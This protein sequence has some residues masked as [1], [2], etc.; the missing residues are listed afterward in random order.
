MALKHKKKEIQ[1][2]IKLFEKEADQ[3]HDI[4]FK[5]FM[6]TKDGVEQNRVFAPQNHAIVLQQYFGRITNTE[7]LINNW[8]SSDLQWGLRGAYSTLC[9]VIEGEQC[10]HFV[11]MAKRTGNIFN[12]HDTEIF[13]S[14]YRLKPHP[15]Y[16][17]VNGPEVRSTNS[18]KLALWLLYLLYYVSK[19]HPGTD[20]C[21]NIEPDPYTLSL[22]ALEDLYN[23]LEVKK[24]D[25]SQKAIDDIHF[26]AAF[27][28]A[29]EQRRTVDQIINH[30][31]SQFEPDSIFY[32]LDYNAQLARP[33][34]D[35]TLQNIYLKQS[36]ILIVFIS[37]DYANKT[38]CGLEWRCLRDII[39]N[40]KSKQ[41]MFIRCDDTILDGMLSI[42]GYIDARTHSETEL[43]ELIATRI[44]VASPPKSF[45]Y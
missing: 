39:K 45:E 23:S 22:L 9:A 15:K 42:D 1:R 37:A 17:S 41:V 12:N 18:D 40:K 20:K 16:A 33:D 27:S 29:G 32:D 34:L 36:E 11:R 4:T 43:A 6:F 2:L 31:R 10:N 26:K 19:T 14:E 38:W 21:E 28:F 25:K 44:N 30:L 35:I 24:I 8:T 13:T 7:K 5:T 3:F